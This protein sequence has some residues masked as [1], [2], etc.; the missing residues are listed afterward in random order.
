M[1]CCSVVL[2]ECGML[3]VCYSVVG[4]RLVVGAGGKDKEAT[5]VTR[6]PVALCG[7]QEGRSKAQAK[8]EE[9]AA[10]AAQVSREHAPPLGQ[11][12]LSRSR[13]P[14]PVTSVP[15]LALAA[16]D[17]VQG[18]LLQAR[19]DAALGLLRHVPAAR[20]PRPL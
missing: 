3:S 17:L 16:Q 5:D 14:E 1:D 7:R 19:R 6:A 10:S 11:M 2:F 12:H 4:P 13:V 15:H 8:K 18:D 9:A 20:R